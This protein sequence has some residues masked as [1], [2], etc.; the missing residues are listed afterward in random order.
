[1][2]KEGLDTKETSIEI[3]I[4]SGIG[5]L[6]DVG[7]DRGLQEIIVVL[8]AEVGVGILGQEIDKIINI[9]SPIN[10]DIVDQVAL[11]EKTR[12]MKTKK[13]KNT[14]LNLKMQ[15]MFKIKRCQFI[16]Q[17]TEM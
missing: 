17:K 8:V 14:K 4:Q 16:I 5:T 9:A 12:T 2:I 3:N 13:K 6:V 7:Q 11:I 10:L 15:I 1:M